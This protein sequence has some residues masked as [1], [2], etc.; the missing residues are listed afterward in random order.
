[1]TT[2]FGK[3]KSFSFSIIL[4]LG[5]IV[6]S[7]I[8][9]TPLDDYIAL[10]DTAYAWNIQD[11]VINRGYTSYHIQLT[12]QQ[13]RDS[14]EVDKP[15]WIHSLILI[16]PDNLC[17]PNALLRISGGQ[18]DNLNF[19]DES[20][21]AMAQ[22]AIATQSIVGNLRI[23]PNQFLKFTDETNPRHLIKGRKEDALVAYSWN[24]YLQTKDPY[25]PILLPMTKS[26]VRAMDAIQEFCATELKPAHPLD[27]FVLSGYSKRGWTI[28]LAAAADSRV[29][30]LIPIVMDALNSKSTFMRA[31]AAYGKFSPVLQ[32]F[33]DIDITK[34]L[35]QPEFEELM[36]ID[37]PFAYFDRLSL[38]KYI[39]NA[40]GDEFFLPDSSRLYYQI[41]PGEKHIRY[42][43][44]A[45]HDLRETDVENSAFAYYQAF[46]AKKPHPKI[47]WAF[48]EHQSLFVLFDQ[49]PVKI[50]LWQAYNPTGRDFRVSTLGK[51]AWTSTSLENFGEHFCI[52]PLST[53][54]KG[55]SAYFVELT[56]DNSL[57]STYTFTTDVFVLP[58]VFPFEF[59]QSP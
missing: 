2:S 58:D 18:S 29:K 37:E 54:E 25:W 4:I 3:L 7:F 51:A 47:S 55:W 23:V 30:A 53:P 31:Y 34:L 38:P 16:V 40:S 27:G 35:V 46:I 52:I 33:L 44:N 5:L 9:G 28:W 43:P 48:D 26:V 39:I 6:P 36:Q 45:N 50:T 56:F 32:D 8:L 24:K 22:A 14:T 12:S 19:A 20:D 13:W 49:E 42:I 17:A 10:P 41:L 21:A 1:M 59:P 57:G 11:K 15:T